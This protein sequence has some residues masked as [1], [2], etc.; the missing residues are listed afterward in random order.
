MTRP[1]THKNSMLPAICSNP[2]CR[3]IVKITPAHMFFRL[4]SPTYNGRLRDSI[5]WRLRAMVLPDVISHGTTDHL[6]HVLVG[7]RSG[8]RGRCRYPR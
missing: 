8:R 4:S 6:I 3:N 5:L 2:P 7:L 1:K